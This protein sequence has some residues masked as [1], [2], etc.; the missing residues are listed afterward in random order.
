MKLKKIIRQK[1]LK[2][3]YSQRPPRPSISN[4]EIIERLEIAV[5]S[6]RLFLEPAMTQIRIASEIAVNRTYLNR[7]L[8]SINLTYTEYINSFRLQYAMKMLIEKPHYSICEIA[9]LSGFCTQKTMDH[10]MKRMVGAT[11]ATIRRR[12]LNMHNTQNAK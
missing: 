9:E 12:E 8:K 4:K 1:V 7:A 10:Y 5:V 3:V 6:K 11:S 2:W